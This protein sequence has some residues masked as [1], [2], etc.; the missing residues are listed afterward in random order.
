MTTSLPISI[1]SILLT[2]AVLKQ[3]NRSFLRAIVGRQEERV[4]QS[5][6]EHS[7]VQEENGVF[8]MDAAAA[9]EILELA[10]HEDVPLYR[11]VLENT[12]EYLQKRIR[13]GEED[14]KETYIAVF[15]RLAK[16]LVA[17]APQKLMQ[18][19]EEAKTLKIDDVFHTYHVAYY[20]GIALAKSERYDEALQTYDTL[21]E[22][23]GLPTR[24]Q[25]QT[26]NARSIAYRLTGRL[27]D[28]LAGYR[29]S[30]RLWRELEDQLYEGVV[31][32]NMGIVAYELQ[33]YEEAERY[34]ISA[35]SALESV[36]P[37]PWLVGVYN[38]L[39]LVY[40]DRGMWAESLRYFDK[41]VSQRRAE[42]A[43]DQIGIGLNNIGEVYLFQGRLDKAIVHLQE[44]LDKMSTRTYRVD[45]Y[46]HLGL[47]YQ[48]QGKLREAQDAYEQALSLAEEIGRREFLPHAHYRLGDLLRHRQKREEALTHFEAAVAIIEETRKPLQEEEIKISLLGR[49]Q[50]IYEALVL[51]CL[52]LGRE[53]EAF[54]WSERARSRAFS[55]G[56]Q[57]Q[58]R[59]TDV[60]TLA[61]VQAQLN[62]QTAIIS[63]FTTGVLENDIPLLRAI[64]KENMLREHLLTTADVIMFT[65]TAD[66]FTAERRFFNP[67]VLLTNTQR[68][69]DPRRFLAPK[70]QQ[71]LSPVILPTLNEHIRN[72]T[73]I[74]HGPLHQVPFAVLFEAQP[75]VLLSYTPSVTIWNSLQQQEPRDVPTLSRLMNSDSHRECLAIAYRGETRSGSDRQLNY[76]EKEASAV[77]QLME[78]DAW[79]GGMMSKANLQ[80]QASG[81]RWLHF[82][83]HGWFN[84]DKPLSSALEI[85]PNERLTADEI[86]RHWDLRAELVTLSACQ[87]G[88]SRVLRGDEPMGLV[89][90]FLYA[91]AR[92]VLVSQWPVE[93]L[94]TYLLMLHFYW[95][96]QAQRVF[97]KDMA[98]ADAQKWL[99]ELTRNDV[100]LLLEDLGTPIE[101]L[102][103]EEIP[104]ADPRHWA[105]FM[106]IA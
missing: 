33:N 7:A 50:Q 45:S 93:D 81:T 90:A 2:L 96:L 88:V 86:L 106:L 40:R 41:F 49:W 47:A 104:F 30:L 60:V 57:N 20:R 78:G 67:N 25:A 85:G 9:A 35:E 74:P 46:L 17:D 44:A 51:L 21:L 102:P 69:Y 48:A 36:G 98:L 22:Q 18:L 55:E 11:E 83:C 91:G 71:S 28:A 13:L 37:N 19:V 100:A 27:G 75:Q 5:L 32:M 4:W 1:N 3:A 15:D 6:A 103:T 79:V 10:Q 82:A 64:P 70:I 42:Q 61:D 56:V 94:P 12:A 89:R 14:F 101:E 16:R 97:E 76:V 59:L 80:F 58:A 43:D 77:A 84:H 95:S 87:T 29:Q 72:V 68:G 54:H 26:L 34:L 53:Q 73:L 92:S 105:A 66:G 63:Y 24:L 62:G 31:L 99:R 39:G 8:Q 38:E 52:E 23:K 65:I